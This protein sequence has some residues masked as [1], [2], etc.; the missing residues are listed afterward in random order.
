[1]TGPV[2]HPLSPQLARPA[3]ALPEG[4]RWW[5]EPK[6]DGF[7]AIVFRDGDGTVVQSRNGRPLDRYFPEIAFPAGR[8]VADG[9][10]VVRDAG[11]RPDFDALQQRIHPA[12]SRVRRLA[13]ETPAV[14]I[15]FDLLAEGDASLLETPFEARREALERLAARDG[16]M[17]VTPGTRDR[18]AAAV[19]LT[20]AEGVIAKDLDAPYRPGERTGMV[21]VRRQ[22]TIDCVVVGWRPGTEPDT[23]GSL[24]LGLY[25]PAGSL[26]VIG[27]SSGFRAAQKRELRAMLEPYATGERGAGEASRWSA[28][29]DLE[30]VAVRPELV[31]EVTFD[32][33][34]GGRIRHGAR[35][36]R[37]RTDRDPATCLVDQLDT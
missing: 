8:W 7:R 15:A 28:E 23:V 9:E 21:K 13:E 12:A 27:H 1:M 16:V 6:W 19:W 11:G 18:D 17:E 4:E 32:H 36:V 34:S 31:V 25:D 33:T 22:R 5:F 30:W 2:P 3:R 35:L 24:I 29:R 37:F 20:D 10:I 14:F 26:R